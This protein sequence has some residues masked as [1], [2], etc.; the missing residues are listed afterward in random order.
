MRGAAPVTEESRL[1]VRWFMSVILRKNRRVSTTGACEMI[2]EAKHAP[3]GAPEG[4]R[5]AACWLAS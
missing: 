5:G 2:G 3:E 4:I 1:P